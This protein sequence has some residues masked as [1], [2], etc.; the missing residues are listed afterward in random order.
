MFWYSNEAQNCWVWIIRLRQ[1]G[2]KLGFE[3]SV[4]TQLSVVSVPFK[5]FDRQ[6]ISVVE[7]GQRVV[8]GKVF[9]LP[10]EYE[11]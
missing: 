3:R 6:W 7:N 10:V 11:E 5:S 8:V 2:H 1:G 4:D 9:V